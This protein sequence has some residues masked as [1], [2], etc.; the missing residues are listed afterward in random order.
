MLPTLAAGVAALVAVPATPAAAG[1]HLPPLTQ[2]IATS[3]PSGTCNATLVAY[4]PGNDVNTDVTYLVTGNSLAFDIGAT[5]QVHCWVEGASGGF[6]DP[7]SVAGA[8]A[9][10]GYAI[11][12]SLPTWVTHLTLCIDVTEDLPAGGTPTTPPTTV[13]SGTS[14]S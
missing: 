13:D 12:S 3:D 7:L 8:T 1:A 2:Q 6:A 4:V 10:A 11:F 5:T 9:G 14:C